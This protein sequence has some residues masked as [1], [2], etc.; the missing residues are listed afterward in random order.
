M[1]SA[2]VRTNAEQMKHRP[3]KC[4]RMFAMHGCVIIIIIV[5]DVNATSNNIVCVVF[6]VQYY[7]LVPSTVFRNTNFNKYNKK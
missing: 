2:Q 6:I 5:V 1:L 4:S 3:K 7:L